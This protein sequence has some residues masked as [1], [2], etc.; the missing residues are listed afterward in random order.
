MQWCLAAHRC[1]S[2]GMTGSMEDPH[3]LQG[4][5]SDKAR[6]TWI[7]ARSSAPEDT[8]PFRSDAMLR[9]SQGS[10]IQ[11]HTLCN[12]TGQSRPGKSRRCTA[13]ALHSYLDTNAQSC[14]D[15]REVQMQPSLTGSSSQHRKDTRCPMSCSPQGSSSPPRTAGS[16]R[17]S[18]SSL[19][20][21]RCH[22]DTPADPPSQQGKRNPLGMDPSPN[23]YRRV[24]IPLR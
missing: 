11:Q 13:R 7:P 16:R 17:Y 5:P 6:D 4:S 1:I 15:A 12:Q 2:R 10:R 19:C 22:G 21:R 8:P 9:E 14:K 3:G 18:Y 23:S 24:W 20:P